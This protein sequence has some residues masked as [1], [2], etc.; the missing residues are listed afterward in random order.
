M[1]RLPLALA[2][3]AVTLAAPAAAHGATLSLGAKTFSPQH[4]RKL[5]VR[6]ALPRAAHVGVEL[7]SGKRHVGWLATPQQ[8]RYVHLR[9]NGRLDNRRVADGVYAVRVVSSEAD[10]VLA[11]RSLR[12]DSAAPRLLRFRAFTRSRLPYAGD[13]ALLTTISPNGDR[14]R[15]SARVSFTLTERA[16]VRFA[17]TRTLSRPT[18]VT[19]QSATL[20]AG[21]H[22]MTWVPPPTTTPR[23]YLALF[24]VRDEAGNRRSYGA[25]NAETGRRKTTPVIRVLGVDAGF[26]RESYVPGETASLT[27]ATDALALQL[28]FF[29]AGPEDV[30]TYDNTVMNGVPVGEPMQ[31]PW[32]S[33]DRPT[34]IPVQLGAW[35]SGVY[36]AKLTAEDGRIGYA[37]FV[38]RPTQLGTTRVAVVIP[39]NTWQAY[40]FRDED[41]NGWG[42]TWYAK[43]AQS[44]VRLGRAFLRRGVPPQYRKYDL[45]FL[46]WLAQQGKQ[47][48]YLTET[49]LEVLDSGDTLAR[50]YDLI[51]YGGHTEYVTTEGVR[52]DP[53]LPRPRRQSDVP[54][55]EQL[56]LAGAPRGERAAPHPQVARPGTPGSGADRGP[57]PG[58]RRRPQPAPVR[59]ARRRHGA[60]ALRRHRSVERRHLRPGARRLRDR[61]RPDDGGEPAGHAGAG[62]GPR[63]LRPGLHGADDLLRDAAG[64]P[65]VRRR[66]DGLRRHR[67]DTERLENAREPLAPPHGSLIL[68]GYRHGML[69]STRRSF[70]AATAALG[71]VL[72]APR[73]ALGARRGAAA[74]Q[75]VAARNLGRRYA[76]DRSL[77]ATV[78]PGVP[79]RDTAAVSF[80]LERPATVRLEAVR[81]AL[82]AEHGV[83][84]TEAELRPRRPRA[85]L[86]TRARTPRWART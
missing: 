27:I 29:R 36:F 46:R 72:F 8:R 11:R 25:R 38:I 84:Q 48:D 6:V 66:G 85:H 71:G 65:G 50:F 81:T 18:V 42:D 68:P 12:I 17:V 30:P 74:P 9:W 2:A 19:E 58:E 5:A 56:L 43:G 35:P 78:A 44:T 31:V 70:L 26:T 41:G 49:D 86:D 64:R 63:P 52:P 62:G 45:G 76:G 55:R 73:A 22:T 10:R 79:G 33:V 16:T 75:A 61:D 59:R 40:N 34:T 14:V 23:T 47:P 13:N 37:P 54:L 1:R 67:A 83:W 24:D 39:T 3:A 7:T 82:S 57:V 53:A 51:V 20:G 4:G 21:R 69:A 77:F 80:R 28:Q 60:V 15:D 32:S